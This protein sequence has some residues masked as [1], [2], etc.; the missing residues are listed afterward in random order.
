VKI[1]DLARDLIELAGLREPDDIRIEY[2]GV[3]PGE[4][5]HEK[6]CSADETL[7]TSEHKKVLI[8][9][10]PAPSLDGLLADLAT[11]ERAAA[12]GDD[13]RVSEILASMTAVGATK[14]VA[15]NVKT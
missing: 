5:L 12:E 8:A 10:G 11:L 14:A 9:T 1:V 6:L 4:K 13:Q 3:R 7:I 2:V 15:P